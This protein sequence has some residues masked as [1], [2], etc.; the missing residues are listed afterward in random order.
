[1]LANIPSLRN[2]FA[3]MMS[4]LALCISTVAGA[5]TV[6]RQSVTIWSQ[7]VRLAGD[8]YTPSDIAEGERLPGVLMP[9]A[10]NS[11]LS[12][13]MTRVESSTTF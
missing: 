1:M 4:T 8:I 13:S 2:A 6:D 10:R 11:A 5:G 12:R 7:G 3:V 9:R